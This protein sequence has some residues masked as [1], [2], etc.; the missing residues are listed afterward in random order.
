MASIKID[1]FG[2]ELPSVSPRSL[3][4]D[5]AQENRNLYLA[6]REFRPL[7]ADATVAACPSGTKTLHRFARKA[8]GSFNADTTTGWITSTQERSY[9][10]GQ[11]NDER[12]ER[13]Y[14]TVDDGSVRPRAIDVNGADRVLGVPRPTK[15]TVS[16]DVVEEFTPEEADSFLYEFSSE[17]VRSAIAG[18]LVTIEPLVRRNGSTIYAGPSSTYGMTFSDNATVD[19]AG[20]G[21]RHGDLWYVVPAARATE[22]RLNELSVGGK[23]LDNGDF[24]AFITCVP[25]TARVDSGALVAALQGLTLPPESGAPTGQRVFTDAQVNKLV[26]KVNEYLSVDRLAR[27]QKSLLDRLAQDYVS[28]LVNMPIVVNDNNDDDIWR[29]HTRLQDLQVQAFNATKAVEDA[30][31]DAFNRL[32]G[33]TQVIGDVFMSEGGVSGIGL[34]TTSRVVDTRFYITTMVTDWGEESE[35]SEVSDIIEADQNDVVTVNRPTL[36]TSEAYAARNITKWRIYRSNSGS[37][38]TA[39]Q[40]VDELPIATATY[41][42]NKKGAE[43]GEVCPSI[44][45][46]EP[47]YRMNAEA[48]GWPKPVV[49][50]NPYIRGLVGMPNGIMAG[51]FDNTVAFCEPYVPYAWPAEYQITTEFPIVGLG[52]FGQTLFVGTTASPYFIY[53]A[54]SASMTAQKLDS[55][56]ACVSRRSIATVQGGVLFA[57]PDGLCVADQNGVNVV[58]AGLFTRED[59][60]LLQPDSMFAIEHEN[61][62]YLFYSGQG[63]GCLTF[64][65]ASKKLG[66]IDLNGSAAFVDRIND[67][68]F[69]ASGTS[70]QAVFGGST[71]RVGKWRSPKVTLQVQSAMA[72]LKVYGNQTAES[73]V[74]VRWYGDGELRHTST[75]TSLQPVRLPPGR[76][77]EHE[78]ELESTARVTRLVLTSTTAE[79]QSL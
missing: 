63:G 77:L 61:V 19:A 1:N 75:V 55:N 21:G 52:V 53:G 27:A 32:I 18:A 6:T 2:G 65:L 40:F 60:Q 66:R 48:D 59:W 12:T 64:D 71:R 35:P 74:T 57:S 13:T 31:R 69:I 46:S 28:A 73:P 11:I 78:V 33:T 39:F 20:F 3:P 42:D 49:G 24:L 62:Y 30:M 34:E 50:S 26:N 41:V 4:A 56:Q 72:W 43:L 14:Y 15:T 37:T 38:S 70:I 17:Q 44:T 54:D 8:D 67:T 68:L 47:P 45:W 76:W 51:F 22:A 29:L 9:V 7:K 25:W 79:L 58:S 36:T 5:A 16:L 10:K 23:T